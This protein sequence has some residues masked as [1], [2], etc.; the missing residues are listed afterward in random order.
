MRK[1]IKSSSLYASLVLGAALAMPAGARAETV[2]FACARDPNT[3]MCPSHWV[4][5]GDTKTVTWH[6]CTSPDS[7]EQR[8]VI[9]TPDRITFDEEFMS[10]HYEFDRRAG[11][12]TITAA[13]SDGKRFDDGEAVCKV[14][15]KY[16]R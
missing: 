2:A 1:Y 12:M 3:D 8:N 6:W 5:D 14:V 4:I 16:E 7:T 11:R 13:G 9:M 10:R 15:P